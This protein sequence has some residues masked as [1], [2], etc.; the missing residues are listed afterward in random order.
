MTV[1]H[2]EWEK[3]SDSDKVKLHTKQLRCW[4]TS[5]RCIPSLMGPVSKLN[6]PYT[7]AMLWNHNLKCRLIQYNMK[8]LFWVVKPD[9]ANASEF[10]GKPKDLLED[11][12][13]IK[14]KEVRESV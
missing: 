8:S 9:P 6:N 5:P 10:I 7:I 1:K 13:N 11:Y 4:R 3:L 14:L 12:A 2:Y